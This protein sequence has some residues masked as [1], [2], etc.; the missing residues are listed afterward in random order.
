MDDVLTTWPLPA[1]TI[2]GVQITQGAQ[3][4]ESGGLINIP[5]Q[6]LLIPLDMLMRKGVLK[7]AAACPELDHF[8]R[9]LLGMERIR[10]GGGRWSY[11]GKTNGSDDLV[12]AVGL[13]VGYACHLHPPPGLWE[14]L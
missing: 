4:T 1:A 14:N 12:M 7:I 5:K 3:I 11:T 9:E 13:A 2:V 6:E 10:T 8:R